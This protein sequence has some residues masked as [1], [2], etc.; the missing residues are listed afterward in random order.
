VRRVDYDDLERRVLESIIRSSKQK[1][2]DRLDAVQKLRAQGESIDPWEKLIA[3]LPE[4][5]LEIW[6]SA[7]T[8][9][10]LSDLL[11][12]DEDAI[13]RF[14]DSGR[15]VL[16]L[17]ARVKRLEEEAGVSDSRRWRGPAES[18]RWEKDRIDSECDA[19]L[20]RRASRLEGKDPTPNGEDA[21]A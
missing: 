16:E 8:R 13:E 21:G 3:Q 6:A 14:G 20:A 7:H 2:K 11:D 18:S 4:D 1:P 17:M 9:Q 5:E 19:Q 10:C 12:Q 15:R